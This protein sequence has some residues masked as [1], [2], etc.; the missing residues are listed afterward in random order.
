MQNTFAGRRYKGC[1]DVEHWMDE[2]A[3]SV[4]KGGKTLWIEVDGTLHN[5][6]GYMHNVDAAEFI[7]CFSRASRTDKTANVLNDI[8]GIRSIGKIGPNTSLF[9]VSEDSVP[10]EVWAENCETPSGNWYWPDRVLYP[11]AVRTARNRT[12][13]QVSR[14]EPETVSEAKLYQL[15][16]QNGNSII[17]QACNEADALELAG[18]TANLDSK[19]GIQTVSEDEKLEALYSLMQQEGLGPQKYEIQELRNFFCEVPLRDVGIGTARIS[20]D[21]TIAELMKLYPLLGTEMIKACDMDEAACSRLLKEA[22]NAER[23]RLLA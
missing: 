1:Y 6:T 8:E 18:I 9:A 17:L 4:Q 11:C 21:D 16:L 15:R 13:L 14:A 5:V 12:I 10:R 22:I 19:L 20:S 23:S 2:L 3:L 7:I